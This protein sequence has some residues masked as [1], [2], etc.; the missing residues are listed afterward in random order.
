MLVFCT[1]QLEPY[2]CDEYWVFI[3]CEQS[4][5]KIGF[6]YFFCMFKCDPLVMKS[7]QSKI[8]WKYD[9]ILI[10]LINTQH[11]EL[12][13]NDTQVNRKPLQRGKGI[14]YKAA[15]FIGTTLVNSHQHPQWKFNIALL[16]IK[17]G[18]RNMKINA[19]NTVLCNTVK[20]TTKDFS[21]SL[22]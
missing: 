12:N 1:C 11:R 19:R 14:S 10:K 5:V 4:W 16:T 18:Y 6:P 21:F 13:R 15:H 9:I 3:I 7:L 22:S 2:L 17:T 8:I 20:L